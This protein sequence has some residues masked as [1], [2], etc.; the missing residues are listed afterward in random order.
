[1]PDELRLIP[2]SRPDGAFVLECPCGYRAFTD[3][4]GKA[5]CPKCNRSAVVAADGPQVATKE[6]RGRK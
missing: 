2:T 3:A 4:H 1:M 5:V 6:Q